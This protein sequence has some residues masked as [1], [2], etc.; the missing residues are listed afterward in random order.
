MTASSSATSTQPGARIKFVDHHTFAD[1]EHKGLRI[2]AA[3]S[4][5]MAR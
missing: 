4:P 5:T 1:P 3:R 2:V